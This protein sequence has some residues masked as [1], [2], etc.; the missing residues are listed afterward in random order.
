MVSTIKISLLLFINI[1]QVM[2]KW[3]DIT[4]F[5]MNITTF[6]QEIQ[7]FLKRFPVLSLWKFGIYVQLYESNL[8][9]LI[10]R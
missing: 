8:L 9:M 3:M 4:N 7:L 1:E 5:P 2:N 6:F 10:N